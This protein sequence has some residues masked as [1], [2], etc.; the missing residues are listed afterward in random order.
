MRQ[1]RKR[2]ACGGAECLSVSKRERLGWRRRRRRLG[3]AIERR[4]EGREEG[5]EECGGAGH[6][7]KSGSR[8]LLTRLMGSGM[9][10][11]VWRL[12]L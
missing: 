1:E 9:V 2:K 11:W 12:L 4:E 8:T 3:S 6:K 7:P 10:H 5:R